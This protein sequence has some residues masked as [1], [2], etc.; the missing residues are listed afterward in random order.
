M[1]TSK[2]PPRT[3]TQEKAVDKDD[4]SEDM[5]AELHRIQGLLGS[6][7]KKRSRGAKSPTLQGAINDRPPPLPP[8]GNKNAE[9]NQLRAQL[10]EQEVA[11]SLRKADASFLQKQL[12]EKD[13]LLAEI[14]KVL[15]QVEARQVELEAE[16]ANLKKQLA[17]YQA[18]SPNRFGLS[19]DV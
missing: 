6:V 17:M 8:T 19:Q 3:P 10:E 12:E 14:S 4:T 1:S 16:N 7:L 18:R 2:S 5:H 11:S 13:N 9:V 15:E